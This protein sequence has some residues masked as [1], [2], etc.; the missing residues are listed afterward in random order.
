MIRIPFFR[1]KG[2]N[3]RTDQRI[4]WMGFHTEFLF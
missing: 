2:I 4:F 1:D 3:K